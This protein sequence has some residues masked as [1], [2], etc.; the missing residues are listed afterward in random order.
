MS[1]LYFIKAQCH[2]SSRKLGFQFGA[3][4]IRNNYNFEIKSNEFNE[5]SDKIC[6]GY[7]ILYEHI[8]NVL[9]KCSKKIIVVGG[10]HSIAAGTIP[11]INEKYIIKKKEEK[12]YASEKKFSSHLKI[13]WIDVHP[14]IMTY[15]FMENKNNDLHEKAVSSLMGLINPVLT[16]QKLLLEPNQFIFYGLHKDNI[17]TVNEYEMKHYTTDK[18]KTLGVD[19]IT[20]S[21]KSFI[22]ND[23]LHV[24]IDMKVFNESFVPSTF[25]ANN[26]GLTPNDVIPLLKE[27]KNNIVSMDI[28]EFNPYLGSKQDCKKTRELERKIIIDTFDIKEK[29]INIFTEDSEFLIYRPLHQLNPSDIGWYILENISTDLKEQIIKNIQNDTIIEIN[30]DGQDILVSKTSMNEQNNISY[31]T[32]RTIQDIALY[33]DEKYAMCFKLLKK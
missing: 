2:M 11:A 28:S 16:N 7:D 25:P 1:D 20:N 18:I 4:D 19:K 15:D 27:L 8:L 9:K 31:Y 5:Q 6:K 29:R 24:S 22:K 3:D 21:I 26:K 32:S 33:P 14:D 12:L 13:L 30:T 23:P 17:D 10:D